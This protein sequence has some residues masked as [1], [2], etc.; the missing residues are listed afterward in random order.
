MLKKSLSIFR[1]ILIILITV[2]LIIELICFVFF[3]FYTLNDKLTLLQTPIRTFY[4]S[5]DRD[6]VQFQ[7]DC[8]IYDK[9]L[10]YRLKAGSCSIKYRENKNPTKYNINKFGLR[11]DNN[12]LEKPEIIILGDSH[13]MGWAND[14]SDIFSTLIEK[15]SKMKVL[16]AAI[17]SYGTA[18]E[19]LMLKQLDQSNLK[20]LVIQYCF[21]DGL[22]NKKFVQGNYQLPISSE[23]VYQDVVDDHVNRLK[24]KPFDLSRMT[25]KHISRIF[26]GKYRGTPTEEDQ[27]NLLK[28]VKKIST[29][30]GPDVKIILFE[31][32][33]NNRNGPRTIN[34]LSELIKKEG[35]AKLED[36]LTL[37]NSSKV[38]DDEDYF[39]LDD[40]MNKSGHQKI[41]DKIM[42]IISSP[43]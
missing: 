9:Q 36:Q 22:E 31:I 39:I 14:E 23:K 16:N 25:I 5:R 33:G 18:R 7:P 28:I 41:A 24:Y 11:D 26:R 21:N 3:K 8:A 30:V 17:S 19:L 6:I 15:N 32:N 4:K 2:L 37:F 13:A 34:I 35:L 20:Y 38:L 12:S 43:N 1:D 29:E 10:T 42:K 40:H 27:E